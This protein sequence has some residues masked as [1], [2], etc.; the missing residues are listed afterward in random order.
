M[1]LEKRLWSHTSPEDRTGVQILKKL[2]VSGTITNTV[3]CSKV[4]FPNITFQSTMSTAY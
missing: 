4:L 3:L 1:E 2:R